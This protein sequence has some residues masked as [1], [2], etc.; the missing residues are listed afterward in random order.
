MNT[1]DTG[2]ECPDEIRGGAA[3]HFIRTITTR[4]PITRRSRARETPNVAALATFILLSTAHLVAS[5]NPLHENASAAA[6]NAS[7]PRPQTLDTC[8]HAE[9]VGRQR[10]TTWVGPGQAEPTAAL[11]AAVWVATAVI[12]A[13]SVAV[14]VAP[15]QERWYRRPARTGSKRWAA[16]WAGQAGHGRPLAAGL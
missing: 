9:N 11:R 16:G 15:D 7:V 8:H 13:S 14:A 5:S 6:P 12:A 1:V 4:M 10:P 2:V 3:A